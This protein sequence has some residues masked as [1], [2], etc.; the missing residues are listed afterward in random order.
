[1]L[2]FYVETNEQ[3]TNLCR[4]LEDSAWLAVDTEFIRENTYYPEFCLLQIAND[5]VAACVDPLAIDDLSDLLSLLYNPS[6]VKVFH[7]ARQDLEIFYHRWQKIPTAVYDT[8][9]AATLTGLGDQPGY[10]ATVK[11]VLGVELD[12]AHVRT[13]WRKRPLDEGQ[14]RYALNDV[15]YLGRLYQK[16]VAQLTGLG[17][18]NWLD[19]DFQILTDPATYQNL[20]DMQWKRIRGQQKLRGK[21]LAVLKQLAA[22]RER[23]AVK[24]NKPRQWIT[25]N[26]NLLQLA[27]RMPRDLS[28]ILRINDL[29][30][31]FANR[32]GEEL[33]ALI[34]DASATPPEEWPQ[35]TDRFPRLTPQQEALADLLMCTLRVRASEHNINPT[36]I[37]SRGDIDK[38]TAG[39][40]SPEVLSGWRNK[41]VGKDLL[42]V[43]EG[44]LYAEVRSGRINLVEVAADS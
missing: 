44:R 4:Q 3:L 2:E 40:R 39:D 6:I 27:R 12:K 34:E 29:D 20:P 23:R 15:V 43:L 22:W 21:Q 18:E 19:D 1:M 11:A 9:L 28:Q 14:I 37:A 30:K 31:N 7:A 17:R 8:Q 10:A 38:L 13:N 41:V 24:K 25:S 5:A 35:E 36:S 26:E 42:R 33:L 16:I 32:F